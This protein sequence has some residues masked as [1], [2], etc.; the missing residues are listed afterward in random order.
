MKLTDILKEL[1]LPKKSWTPIP[2][3]ELKAFEQNIFQLIQTAYSPI[4]GNPRF[5]KKSD[6]SDPTNEYEYEVI[7]LDDDPEADAVSAS[8]NTPAGT[9]LTATGHDG[10]REAKSSVINHKAEL[11]KH[12]GCYIEASGKMK[13]VL[14]GKGVA[15]VTDKDTV[16]KALKGKNIEWH[17]DGTYTRDIAG[18]RFIK[19]LL[20]KPSVS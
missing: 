19:T 15:I 11:L 6:V 16:V 8:K 1:N 7:N 17:G 5:K 4:G 20:G 13:D 10:S 9:K 3:Q 2:H 18:I 14:V 12:S